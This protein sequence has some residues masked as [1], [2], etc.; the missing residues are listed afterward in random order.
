MSDKTINYIYLDYEERLRFNSLGTI[1]LSPLTLYE[2]AMKSLGK[3][4]IEYV[5]GELKEQLPH[6]YEY[7]AQ[8]RIFKKI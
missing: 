4:D 3:D 5:I 7:H 6:A 8:L 1:T 2:Y